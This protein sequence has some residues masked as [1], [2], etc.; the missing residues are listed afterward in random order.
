MSVGG[1]GAAG[2]SEDYGEGFYYVDVEFVA[3]VFYVCAAPGDGRVGV[4]VAV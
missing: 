2:G 3:G 1:E 4:G